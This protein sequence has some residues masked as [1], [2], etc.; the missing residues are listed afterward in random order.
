MVIHGEESGVEERKILKGKQK[1]S[2]AAQMWE[3]SIYY[4][5]VLE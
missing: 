2:T 5:W 1:Q 3:V 4:I